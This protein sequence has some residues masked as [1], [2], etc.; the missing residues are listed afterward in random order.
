MRALGIFKCASRREV[1]LI[2]LSRTYSDWL[3]T[4]QE[5]EDWF[6][7]CAQGLETAVATLRHPVS[8][9]LSTVLLIGKGEKEGS[10]VVDS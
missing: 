8:L 1:H 9:Y 7:R 4:F 10:L 3:Y 6:L 2:W 5:A